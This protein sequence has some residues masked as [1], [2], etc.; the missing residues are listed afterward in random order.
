VAK[1][2]Q[3]HEFVHLQPEWKPEDIKDLTDLNITF[4]YLFTE[5]QNNGTANKE[6]LTM[7]EIDENFFFLYS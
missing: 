6:T 7:K 4:L 5:V 3:N 2:D 1:A